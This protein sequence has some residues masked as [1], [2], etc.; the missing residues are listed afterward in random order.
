MTYQNLIGETFTRRHP[1]AEY[2][3]E[4]RTLKITGIGDW[5]GVPVV[6]CEVIDGRGHIAM[7]YVCELPDELL[8]K[9]GVNL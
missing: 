1:S 4:T 5:S 9:A 2:E 3:N 8:T 7:V 6:D